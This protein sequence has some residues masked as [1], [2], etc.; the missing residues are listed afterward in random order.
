MFL[1][2]YLAFASYFHVGLIAPIRAQLY[3]N[4]NTVTDGDFVLPAL[5]IK[6]DQTTPTQ[7]LNT[8]IKRGYFSSASSVMNV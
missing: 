8:P 6:S 2:M 1:C 7:F 5:L 4:E 3:L